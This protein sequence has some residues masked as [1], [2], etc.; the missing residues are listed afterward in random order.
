MA[1]VPATSK[2]PEYTQHRSL[3]LVASESVHK[4][5]FDLGPKNAREILSFV[6]QPYFGNWLR[7]SDT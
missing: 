7:D 4:S 6:F 2:I 3:S 5:L 1:K